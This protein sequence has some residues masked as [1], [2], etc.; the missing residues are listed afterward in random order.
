MRHVEEVMKAM[1]T[2][3][4]YT[5]AHKLISKDCFTKL[6]PDVMR[7]EAAGRTSENCTTAQ[8]DTCNQSWQTIESVWCTRALEKNLLKYA[9]DAMDAVI[10]Y[11][12]AHK[13]ISKETYQTHAKRH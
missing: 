11:A 5:I 7:R 6:M 12:M 9:A 2:V 13:L 10:Q 4:Q 1:E 3:I 8:Q